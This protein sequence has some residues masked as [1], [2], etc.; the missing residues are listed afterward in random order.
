MAAAKGLVIVGVS[1][2]ATAL[3]LHLENDGVFGLAAASIGA[4]MV[5]FG[6]TTVVVGDRYML[7]RIGL[8]LC[9][10]AASIP[11]LWHAVEYWTELEVGPNIELLRV[12]EETP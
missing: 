1:F 3:L 10:G 12:E 11:L 5:A 6:L 4:T 7:A 8:G 9:A 2:L